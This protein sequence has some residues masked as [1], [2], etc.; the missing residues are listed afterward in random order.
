LFRYGGDEF[1]MIFKDQSKKDAKAVLER[2]THQISTQ[3]L[4]I[5]GLNLYVTL[6]IGLCDVSEALGQKE[7]LLKLIDQ[8]MY[9]A[10]ALGKNK[11]VI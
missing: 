4:N 2:I 8:R 7:S 9:E 5:D 3:G 11:I 10:K 6:S 1:V